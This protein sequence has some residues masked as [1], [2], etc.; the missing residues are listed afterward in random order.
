MTSTATPTA[1]AYVTA[2]SHP[3]RV[4]ALQR[5]PEDGKGVSPKQLAAE[6]GVP[7]ANVAYHIGV[8]KKL[9][10]IKLKGREPRRGA[11]E[12][13]YVRDS[14]IAHVCPTCGRPIN[15]D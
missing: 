1:A 3:L 6:F 12:H 5:I 10:L 15:G 2:M 14:K 8:L 4:N 11:V 13:F 7:L 9:K